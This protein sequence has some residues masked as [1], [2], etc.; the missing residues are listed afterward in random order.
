MDA[1]VVVC[2]YNRAESLRRT[3]D[4]IL[5]QRLDRNIPW[6]V[7]V[8][9][10]NSKDYTRQ[11]VENFKERMDSPIIRY[12][13]EGKQGLSYARNR[14]VISARG[15]YI[16]FTDDDVSPE[17]NWLNEIVTGM[18]HYGCN[19]C[20]GWIGP[21]WAEPPPPWLT[22]RFYGFLA[23]RIDENGP[24]LVTTLNEA[25]FGANMAFC[26]SVFDCYG[27]FDTNRGR[28]GN[29]LWS[30]EDGEFFQRL[31]HGGAKVMYFPQARVYHHIDRYRMRKHYFRKWRFQTSYNISKTEEIVGSRRILGVPIYIMRQT[32][33][34]AYKAF[35]SR[36]Y[37]EPS[38][39]LHR[40][41][42]FSHFLGA[43]YGL[44]SREK[45]KRRL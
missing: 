40:E 25:P 9:D 22:K 11:V 41:M 45:E 39:V 20:G 10:N 42:I 1:S 2:T 37:R 32:L 34:A 38:E 7:I 16:L 6:E 3:L 43:V 15:K 29:R 30:G 31:F 28:V 14:G 26:K 18:A 27:L 33:T 24:K 12:E 35:V 8:V 23:L 4:K 36:I 19:A 21:A 44:C 5:E 13:F 17:P